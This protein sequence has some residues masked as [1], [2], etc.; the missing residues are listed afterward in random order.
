MYFNRFFVFSVYLIGPKMLLYVFNFFLHV[1]MYLNCFLSLFFVYLNCFCFRFF[2]FTGSEHCDGTI[3]CFSVHLF[4]ICYQTTGDKCDDT[5]TPHAFSCCAEPP[6]NS[7]VV[8]PPLF[9]SFDRR[10]DLIR[11]ELERL[12]CNYRRL[13]C[14]PCCLLRPT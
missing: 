13:S 9:K 11:F 4:I 6:H 8:S 10:L 5:K 1:F 2:V 14:I 12:R 7:L 3:L